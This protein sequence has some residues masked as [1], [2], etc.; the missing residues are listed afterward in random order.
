MTELLI[1][2]AFC[3]LISFLHYLYSY[4]K[5]SLERWKVKFNR[6]MS[7][8]VT[9]LVDGESLEIIGWNKPWDSLWV[10]LIQRFSTFGMNQNLLDYQFLIQ[11]FQ[12]WPERLHFEKV[13][14]WCWYCWFRDHSLCFYAL[15]SFFEGSFMCWC[16]WVCFLEAFLRY[17]IISLKF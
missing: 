12:D 14:R 6:L 17:L 16:I 8:D 11:K 13:P 3:Y 7:R 15:H 1:V 5:V 2:P 10:S 4:L 9:K